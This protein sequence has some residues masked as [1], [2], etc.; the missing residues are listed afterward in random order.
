[1]PQLYT[2]AVYFTEEY[3][4]YNRVGNL[5][6]QIGKNPRIYALIEIYRDIAGVE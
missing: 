2:S 3:T 1:M 5:K 6:M 4:S